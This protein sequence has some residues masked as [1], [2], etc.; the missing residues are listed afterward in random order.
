VRRGRGRRSR[1]RLG[2]YSGSGGGDALLRPIRGRSRGGRL[3]RTG[4]ARHFGRG[5]GWRTLSSCI[6]GSRNHRLSLRR[7]LRRS[8]RCGRG[9]GPLRRTSRRTRGWL[10]RCSRRSSRL[11]RRGWFWRSRLFRLDAALPRR[12]GIHIRRQALTSPFLLKIRCSLIWGLA[13]PND[14]VPGVGFWADPTPLLGA[15]E[16]EC[17]RI[18]TVWA[19]IDVEVSDVFQQTG[20]ASSSKKGHDATRGYAQA[21]ER[22]S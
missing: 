11:G 17:D 16:I 14:I 5:G 9:R 22:R 21:R 7:R 15:Q 10:R 6:R 13:N 3:S 1:R 4:L 2:F 20:H 18:P 8:R 12:S 19:Q